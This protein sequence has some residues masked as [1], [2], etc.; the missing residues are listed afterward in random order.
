MNPCLNRAIYAV[1]LLLL[2]WQGAAQAAEAFPVELR[3]ITQGGGQAQIHA[4]GRLEA[5]P[6]KLYFLTDGIMQSLK[7]VDGQQVKKY[8]LLATLDPFFIKKEIEQ[9]R[10]EVAFSRKELSRM[11]ALSS[12]EV[13]SKKR[14][15]T[16]QIQL[17]RAQ[18][19]LQQAQERL[20][21]HNLRA[22]ASGRILHRH[23][24]HAQ[25]ITTA[26]PIFDFKADHEPW[27]VTLRIAA[28]HMAL[29][30]AKVPVKLH[31]PTHPH[32][33]VS[34]QVRH[35]ALSQGGGDGHYALKV[36][37]VEKRVFFRAGLQVQATL[38]RRVADSKGI[39]PIPLAA[40][41]AIHGGQADLYVLKKDQQQV[42]KL[43]VAFHRLEGTVAQLYT[44]LSPY[45]HYVYRGQ[46]QLR[47]GVK[48]RI[49]TPN[50]KP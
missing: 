28:H 25:P 11:Q 29:V 16:A 10:Q 50:P 1:A 17:A 14:F 36:A 6:Q 34:G 19:A 24:D 30:D 32:E 15:D 21:R 42:T 41:S 44:D 4:Y 47:D 45:S 43:R 40:L 46:H 9:H 35:S 49:L 7:V 31:F 22:P 8:S 13:A 39:Y 48:V 37:V 23:L 12:H 38:G 27:L 18:N 33:D 2:C 3:A 20:K 26:T 5:T